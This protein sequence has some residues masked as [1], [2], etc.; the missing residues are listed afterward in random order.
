MQA[1][2][3]ILEGRYHMGLKTDIAVRKCYSRNSW[4]SLS[5]N[6]F[7]SLDANKKPTVRK[8]VGYQSYIPPVLP[9]TKAP[10]PRSGQLRKVHVAM[11]IKV[12]TTLERVSKTLP[13][14]GPF[15]TIAQELATEFLEVQDMAMKEEMDLTSRSSNYWDDLEVS[16]DKIVKNENVEESTSSSSFSLDALRGLLSRLEAWND[17][18]IRA[19]LGTGQVLSSE[20]DELL[21]EARVMGQRVELPGE[22][23][24]K[25]R[26]LQRV[27]ESFA[28]KVFSKLDLKGKDKVPL[29][30]LADLM[31]EA[32]ALPI[33]TEEVRFFRNQRGR[34]QAIC[35]SAQKASRNKSLDKS[36]DV[37]IEAAEV[38]AILPELDFLKNQVSMGEWVQKAISKTDKKGSVS[39]QTIEQLFEDPSAALIKPEEC[40]IMRVL[41]DA[42][43]EAR[44]WQA[45]A[46][47]ILA[48]VPS[49]DP[50]GGHSVKRMPT[51]EELMVLQDQ[52]SQLS[53]ICIPVMSAH[54]E[55]VVRRAKAW[56]KKQE[57]TLSGTWS[58]S[59]AKSLLEEGRQISAQVDLNP[60]FGKLTKEVTSAESWCLKAKG[61]ISSLTLSDIDQLE[62]LVSSSFKEAPPPAENDASDEDDGSSSKRQ[63]TTFSSSSSD[64][65][66]GGYIA[67]L[68]LSGVKQVQALK[69]YENALTDLT[70]TLARVEMHIVPLLQSERLPTQDQLDELKGTLG[71]V[72]DT[73]L[74]DD[75]N[76]LFDGAN[77]WSDRAE[78]VL[79]APFPRQSGVVRSLAS[80]IHDLVGSPMRYRRW[81]EVVQVAKEEVWAHGL[82]FISL[83]L[84]E[85]KLDALIR[86]CPFFQVD[87]V[88]L[89]AAAGEKEGRHSELEIASVLS[90]KQED[91]MREVLGLGLRVEADGLKPTSE[92]ELL[93]ICKAFHGTYVDTCNDLLTP[94]RT[95]MHTRKE[96][97]F[98]LNQL[99]SS[100]LLLLPSLATKV[101]IALNKNSALDA[102]SRQLEER[103]LK[104]Y[105]D[106]EQLQ[107]TTLFH[108]LLVLLESVEFAEVKVEHFDAVFI[109]IVGKLLQYQ[110]GVRGLFRWDHDERVTEPNFRPPL[111]ELENL[112]SKMSHEADSVYKLSHRFMQEVAYIASAFRALETAREWRKTFAAIVG[113]M[114]GGEKTFLPEA[115]GPVSINMLKKHVS[116]WAQLQVLVPYEDIL[117]NAEMALIDEWSRALTVSVSGRAKQRRRASLEEA[118]D[119]M[120][121]APNPFCVNSADFELL[122]SQ[123]AAAQE[124][125]NLSSNL[126]VQSFGERSKIALPITEVA[127]SDGISAELSRLLKEGKK[128]PIQI[129]TEKAIELEMRIRAV[130]TNLSKILMR[131]YVVPLDVV[132][133]FLASVTQGAVFSPQ[134]E[135]EDSEETVDHLAGVSFQPSPT[136]VDAVRV[137]I[138]T[139]QKWKQVAARFMALLP[140][141]HQLSGPADPSLSSKKASTPQGEQNFSLSHQLES[142]LNSSLNAPPTAAGE[143]SLDIIL[144]NLDKEVG[145]I[146]IA[147]PPLP[148]V[149][150]YTYPLPL[151][152]LPAS[153]GTPV[154]SSSMSSEQRKTASAGGRKKVNSAATKSSSSTL[155]SSAENPLLIRGLSP[156]H[157]LLYQVPWTRA[158]MGYLSPLNEVMLGKPR[159]WLLGEKARLKEKLSK[160]GLT[161]ASAL[162]LLLQHRRYS[163]FQTPESVRAR[164][165]AAQSLKAMKSCVS[166][167][168]FLMP[169]SVSDGA[170]IPLEPWEKYIQPSSHLPATSTVTQETE[171]TEIVGFLLQLDALAFQVP[172]KYRLLMLMLDMY[173]W[174]VRSQCVCHHLHRDARPRPW[175]GDERALARWASTP[176]PSDIFSALPIYASPAQGDPLCLH[177]IPSPPPADYVLCAMHM[178][179]YY[180]IES[181]R[182]F[183]RVMSDMCELCFSVTTTDQESVLWISC[184]A[185]EK[186]FHGQ[187]AGQNQSSTSFTCPHCVDSNPNVNPERKRA[188]QALLASMPPPRQNLTTDTNRK[189]DAE[190][191][192]SEA[193]LQAIVASV[194]PAE[195]GIFKRLV[196]PP[197][198]T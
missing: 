49:V 75:I 6:H 27:G 16:L 158:G 85:T 145:E 78:M 20:V 45:Q 82:R 169:K 26:I 65:T 73:N 59:D 88:N 4:M 31:K 62:P 117:S 154:E 70:S 137:K 8:G 81:A 71:I 198:Q 142:A 22:L 121:S 76:Q 197:K 112:W 132:E 108:D 173:D 55:G 74:E 110:A 46:N 113:A 29:R 157:Q 148:S 115:E 124:L 79:S 147:D 97:E 177:V 11:D 50:A 54:I 123:V 93:K 133:P 5:S 191:L 69:N 182:H 103:F 83:P 48:G 2:R 164:S 14:M 25:L 174:R 15:N 181:C 80:L 98:F 58:L 52:H 151:Y 92:I 90:R 77:K 183:I 60:E 72:R 171:E 119:L 95:P 21:E 87:Q 63:K 84:H 47:K 96:A 156:M 68:N 190:A 30:V 193:K 12:S 94:R 109:P 18:S 163:L 61:L 67:R 180:V 139:T 196:A 162:D 36:K 186:W 19:T 105:S 138:E 129:G 86:A 111:A 176:P 167:F 166:R 153:G 41:K 91:W 165:L 141:Q 194:N 120:K 7:L 33:E 1:L 150:E 51:I 130:N 56:I 192:L 160:P 175:A 40:E 34:I 146:E 53:K 101:T 125:R 170:D 188:A 39:I 127:E 184:D 64:T 23:L 38:R 136:L 43:A 104:D 152:Q 149:T 42:M 126:I 9:G 143:K 159:D 99:N 178:S 135:G 107:D 35:H 24:T 57:R 37:T 122:A 100:P 114:K 155:T 161:L 131:P 106:P 189:I 185:C 134:Q 66:S 116:K 168:A 3:A 44:S 10:H 179:F 187:C 118:E 102:A 144:R 140:L 195:I 172:T 13:D 89:R 28:A 17:R 32:E 128:S